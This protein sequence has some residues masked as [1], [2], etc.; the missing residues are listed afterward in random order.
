VSGEIVGNRMGP[1]TACVIKF[2]PYLHAGPLE[3]GHAGLIRAVSDRNDA[4]ELEALRIARK[5]GGFFQGFASEDRPW[6]SR[7]CA[8]IIA[9]HNKQVD[10]KDLHTDIIFSE[11][12]V[13]AQ[14]KRDMK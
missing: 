8:R 9:I 2:G 10:E 1:I 4:A 7:P 11:D 5:E 12:F 3:E 14:R 6:I 13:I